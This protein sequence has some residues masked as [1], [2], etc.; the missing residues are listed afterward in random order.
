MLLDIF[1]IT[2]IFIAGFEIKFF[3]RKLLDAN[4][5]KVLNLLWLYHVVIS[6]TFIAYVSQSGGDALGYWFNVKHFEAYDKLLLF[7]GYWYHVHV[8]D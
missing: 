5:R 7:L 6:L 8:R 3:F 4:D 1:I 2:T